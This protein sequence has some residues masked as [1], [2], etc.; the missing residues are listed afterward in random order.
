MKCSFQHSSMKGTGREGK[1]VALPAGFHREPD[2]ALGIRQAGPCE[3]RDGCLESDLERSR[4]FQQPIVTEI[5]AASRFYPAEEYHQNYYQKNPLR[6]KYYRPAAAASGV[7][8]RSGESRKAIVK[9]GG[10]LTRHRYACRSN[11]LPL[12]AVTARS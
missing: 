9:S 12:P 1:V 3:A 5:V 8:K 10:E 11:T 6:Y 2:G 7:S 4:R